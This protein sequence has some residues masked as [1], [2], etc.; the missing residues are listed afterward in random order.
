MASVVLAPTAVADLDRLIRSRSLPA[1]MHERVKSSL[2]QLT[3]FPLLGTPLTG[4]WQGF[5]LI[6]GPWLWVL[7]V[8]VCDEE[9]D[10]V[11]VVTIRD[12]RPAEPGGTFAAISFLSR[13]HC[14]ADVT[15][16]SP[17]TLMNCYV[18]RTLAEYTRRATA[19]G[20]SARYVPWAFAM[21]V[22]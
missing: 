1:T 2:R 10:R 19:P 22:Q 4:R 3:T 12:S 18:L 11:S 9:A 14:G 8:H 7:L 21:S 13:F 20:R 6:L 17:F 15:V 16:A 5:G